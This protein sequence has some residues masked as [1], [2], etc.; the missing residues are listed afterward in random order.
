MICTFVHF[1][2]GNC[3]ILGYDFYDREEA[4]MKAN[5]LIALTLV[6]LAIVAIVGLFS[7]MFNEV[8]LVYD[9]ATKRAGIRG[10]KIMAGLPGDGTPLLEGN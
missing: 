6:L 4:F 2:V 7:T 1:P 9:P 5:D 3:F 10:R 8:E